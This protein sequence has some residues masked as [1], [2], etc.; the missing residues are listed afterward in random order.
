MDLERLHGWSDPEGLVRVFHLA[1]VG[2]A[3]AGRNSPGNVK[4]ICKAVVCSGCEKTF[5]DILTPERG[6]V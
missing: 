2:G 3:G 6:S 1:N 5:Q 4:R